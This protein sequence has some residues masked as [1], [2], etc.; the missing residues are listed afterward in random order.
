MSSDDAG[1][2]D[3]T[4]CILAGGSAVR[5]GGITKPLLVVNQKRVFDAQCGVLTQLCD[6]IVV[7]TAGP[8]DWTDYPLVI[9]Q[10][11]NAGPLAG[12]HAALSAT[13]T[14]QWLLVIA[15]DMPFLQRDVLSLLITQARGASEV[16]RAVAFELYGKP[17]PLCTMFH[18]S[19]LDLITAY[20][21]RGERKVGALLQTSE[22]HTC[23]VPEH[24]VRL[25]DP[26]LRSFHNVNGPDDLQHFSE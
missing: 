11:P 2:V 26:T 17:Q 25:K 13:T 18:R 23:F 24:V 5:M 7:S 15:G 16:V 14:R 19:A 9:D 1:T 4:G 8:A 6:R 10:I 3:V 21:S 12:I 22:M 20:L